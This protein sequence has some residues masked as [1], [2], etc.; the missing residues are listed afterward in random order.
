MTSMEVEQET[1][2]DRVKVVLAHGLQS[3]ALASLQKRPLYGG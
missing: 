3:N 2:A 1:L